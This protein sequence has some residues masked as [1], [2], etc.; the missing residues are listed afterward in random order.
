MRLTTIS[1]AGLVALYVTLVVGFATWQYQGI[2]DAEQAAMTQTA[3][4]IG[5]EIASAVS[6][7]SLG[8]LTS[9]EPWA[10]MRMLRVLHGVTKS[11]TVVSSI[12]VVGPSGE[13]L[14]SDEFVEVG[15]QLDPP[16]TVFAAGRRPQLV[17]SESS[18]GTWQLLVPLGVEGEPPGYVRLD[19]ASRHLTGV[20]ARSQ[21]R[22]WQ[23][24]LAGL[25]VIAGLGI[26]LH[27]L[28][29]RRSADVVTILEGAL[30]G[31]V[32]VVP[33]PGDEFATVYE[34]AGRVS[35]ELLTER[36]RGSQA[37]HRLSA[38]S[39]VMDVGVVLIAR[40]RELEFANARACELLGQPD[41]ES[42]VRSWPET[43]RLLEQP[44]AE[45]E[46]KKPPVR[47][48]V[49]VAN[50]GNPRR[51]RC[52]IY[53]FF[54]EPRDTFLV[55]VR[56]RAMVDALENDLLLAS[57]L[58]GLSRVYRSITHDI[59]APL[60]SMVLNLA[61]LENTLQLD[62]VVD[63]REK[64]SR[65]EY[66]SVLREEL[67]R[68]DR[69]LLA[70]L[71]ETAP[72]TPERQELDAREVQREIKRLLGAQ[73][74]LQGVRLATDLP[75]TPVPVVGERDRLKQALLNVAINGLE[76]MP[77]GGVLELGLVARDGFAEIQVADRGEGMPE[78]VRQRIFDLHFTT[79]AG[80]TGIGLY[81]ARAII[82][83]H[84][85]EVAVDSTPGEGSR[86]QIRLPLQ[87]E[88]G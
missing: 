74:Q 46:R 1:T 83:A 6:E 39:L 8:Q 29:A 26:G 65:A 88:G 44:L 21:R 81:V 77:D 53:R 34:A 14:A 3:E 23:A 33:R 24:A 79:K 13:V 59:R 41:F 4:L 30:A 72:P 17:R 62:D 80:G 57:Q 75:E 16:A 54:E 31:R 7:A 58:R 67:E 45:A 43:R 18:G 61:L 49:E 36:E 19:L 15:K 85:G 11:S 22:I 25:V 73:A 48:D 52:Q 70:L 71:A 51:L 82:E 42:L 47:A 28:L 10:R 76:S 5:Q 56:D 9:S 37:R 32:P 68:L 20:Y 63:E 12:A 78:D 87:T 60:N 2:A 27:L 38:L 69:S 50:G 64:A 40:G 84:G 66:L 86:F 55:L 35:R